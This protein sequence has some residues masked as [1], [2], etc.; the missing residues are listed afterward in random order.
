MDALMA[1]ML[2]SY[3]T[4]FEFSRLEPSRID[5]ASSA[6]RKHTQ[7]SKSCATA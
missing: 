2:K 5:I 4:G 3:N 6:S 1:V 7:F